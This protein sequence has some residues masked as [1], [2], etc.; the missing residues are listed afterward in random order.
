MSLIDQVDNPKKEQSAFE[1]VQQQ[2]E[3]ISNHWATV[4]AAL[5]DRTQTYTHL[6]LS[7]FEKLNTQFNTAFELL[8]KELAEPTLILA[9][10]G[11]TSSGKSTIV[12]LLCGADIMPRMTQEMSAGVVYL[13]HSEDNKKYLKINQTTGALWECGEWSDLGDEELC[14]KLTAVMDCFNAHKGKD[15]PTPPH[16]EITYPIACFNNPSLLA[17]STIPKATKFKLLDLPGLRNSQDITNSEAIKKC[18]DALCLV[19]YNMEETDETRRAQLI[20][21]V[22]GQV[23]TMGGS[24]AR[25]LFVLNRI[26][27]FNKDKDSER[28]TDEH[29]IKVK[30]EIRTLLSK[31]L[32]ELSDEVLNDLAYSKL[33]SLPALHAQCAR[34][35]DLS[36][37]LTAIKEIE[38]HFS[39]LIPEEVLNDL[40]RNL[41]KSSEHDLDR[42]CAAVWQTSHAADFFS[43]LNYHIERHFPTLVI[44]SIIYRFNKEAEDIIGH[45]IR[46]C[47]IELNS[48][49][50]KYEDACE[51]L[52]RK[53]SLLREFVG[54]ATKSLLEPLSKLRNEIGKQKNSTSQAVEDWIDDLHKIEIFQGKIE[55]KEFFPLFAWESVFRQEIAGILENVFNCLRAGKANVFNG[56]VA[57]KFSKMLQDKL[58]ITLYHYILVKKDKDQLKE[59]NNPDDLKRYLQDFMNEISGIIKE[60]IG[61][62]AKQEDKRVEDVL[63]KITK[64]YAFYLKKGFDEKFHEFGLSVGNLYLNDK[65]SPEIAL[66]E[67]KAEL[68]IKEEER[69][70]SR[71]VQ[72]RH[73]YTLWLIGHEEEER[74]WQ[75]FK[76]NALPDAEQ[77]SEKLKN[78]FRHALHKMLN[79][80]VV[81]VI[82]RF[83]EI[84]SAVEQNVESVI[85][86][87][88]VKLEIARNNH[89]ESYDD[90]QKDW[91]CIEENARSLQE[92]VTN[93]LPK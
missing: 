54:N 84:E 21:E 36:A 29:V 1:R 90:I 62:V 43:T 79:P 87:F 67:I 27:A 22:L 91:G 61:N 35:G 8:K 15:Q 44:P 57:N 34:Q 59:D 24:P 53:N 38:R 6:E 30:N 86:D 76:F 41:G 2:V 10:T 77:V 51:Q 9:T 71:T 18:R 55:L 82:S 31:E 56:V 78:E 70:C 88:Q 66:P 17:L 28:R 45:V 64:A 73:W 60:H 49:K 39:P 65:K 5:C 85:K 69:L 89:E 52:Y 25:M 42:V 14:E 37:K 48:S 58:S 32:I 50:E 13:H 47:Y 4:Y 23:K 80:F 7:Q 12:N 11:T 46:T 92:S 63:T 93:L 3:E 74:Y 16:I 19:A 81:H 72:E 20:E 33:S 40:P 26:D 68:V 75:G 83:E